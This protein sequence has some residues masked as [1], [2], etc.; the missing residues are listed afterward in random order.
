LTSFRVRRTLRDRM[1]LKSFTLFPLVLIAVWLAVAPV[2]AQTNVATAFTN[3]A[4]ANGYLQIQEQLHAARL[5]IE[6]NSLA[7][8]EDAKKNS[9]ALNARLQS[10]E[11]TVSAQ[12]AGDAEAARKTQQLTLLVAGIF[13]LAGL[14][15]LLLMVYFQWRAFS[16]IAQI[17][18]QQQTAL[19]NA[20]AV[21]QLAAPGRAAVEV[22]NARLLDVV[23]QLE[24]KI[25]ELESGHGLVA[26]TPVM[27]SADPL[28]GAQKFLDAG[29]PQKA[30][31]L[32][33]RLLAAQPNHAEALLKKAAALEKLGRLEDALACCD[34]ALAG[35]GA[36][37]L[38]L[39]AKGGLLNRL[40]RHAEAIDCFEQ[41]L[42][43][44][45]TK[46]RG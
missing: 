9:D 45:E 13:G 25:I 37:T 31:E 12:R 22:S 43:A 46:A 30:L 3:D 39:L 14:G 15:I 4:V 23:G 42:R 5:A 10:L 41:T 21:H 35:N 24:K 33:E 1:K 27:K 28:A 40:N 17:S 7:A 18:A 29:Q 32:L 44:Q 19:A 26:E 34:R 36:F 11:Q 2:N 6:A 20:S 38:A 8:A 16:Q